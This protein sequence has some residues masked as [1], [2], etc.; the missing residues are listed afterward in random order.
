MFEI[1]NEYG[2]T[3]DVKAPCVLSICRYLVD[4]EKFDLLCVQVVSRAM[5]SCAC[6]FSPQMQSQRF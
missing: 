3:I 6:V 5:P 2:H 1:D 4:G